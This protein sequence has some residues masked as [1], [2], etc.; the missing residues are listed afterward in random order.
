MKLNPPASSSDLEAARAI[1]RRLHDRA[2]HKERPEPAP[3]VSPRPEPTV[4]PAHTERPAPEP[5]TTTSEPEGFAPPEPEAPLADAQSPPPVV[6]ETAEAKAEPEALDL[7]PSEEPAPP[8]QPTPADSPL[9][10]PGIPEASHEDDA[11]I[12]A[13]DT[14]VFEPEAPEPEPPAPD[15]LE[16]VA[17]AD[18]PELEDP[19]SDDSTPADEEP[20]SPEAAAAENAWAAEADDALSELDG[21]PAT[22]SLEPPSAPH[23]E[24]PGTSGVED[25]LGGAPADGQAPEPVFDDGTDSGAAGSP[26]DLVGSAEPSWEAVAEACMALAGAHGAMLVDTSGQ[27]LTARGE[28]PEPGPDA[29]AGR[30]VSMMDRT[31]KEAP[32]RSVSAPIAGQHLTAWRIP[33]QEGYFTAVFMG[34]APLSADVR[35][36]I[37]EHIRQ[38]IGG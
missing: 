18:A 29:I 23:E 4:P 31:L 6:A 24:D 26:D 28:W 38:V 19:F 16:A 22:P 36:D 13:V 27:V 10:D 7:V 25:L 2:L 37:D 33:A 17:P 12:P 8:D 1:A 34:D 15:L 5:G 11:A 20:A 3:P 30:L 21:A 32:T 9:T 35:P 14:P